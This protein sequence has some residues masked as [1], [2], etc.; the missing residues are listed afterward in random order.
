MLLS[1]H[2]E[3]VDDF[4]GVRTIGLARNHVGPLRNPKEVVE[5]QIFSAAWVVDG[6]ATLV[7]NTARRGDRQNRMTRTDVLA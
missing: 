2:D 7:G 6:V 4:G 1:V 5:R 3:R